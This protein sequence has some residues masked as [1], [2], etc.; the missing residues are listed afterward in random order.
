MDMPEFLSVDFHC[1]ATKVDREA[2]ALRG[3]T[4]AEAGVFRDGRGEFDRRGLEQIAT[5]INAD[6]Q[7]LKSRF[8]HP[9]FFSDGLGRF[10]GRVRGA[11][12][13]STLGK[14][15]KRVPAVKADLYFD[16]SAFNTPDGDLAGYTMSL[17]ES[18]S[19]AISSSLVI[20]P[21]QELQSD[22]SS[23][24]LWFPEELKASD[25]VE[26]GAAVG[27]LLSPD[28][29][30]AR[31]EELLAVA[32]TGK[33]RDDAW[34]VLDA[35]LVKAF[36]DKPVVQRPKLDSLSIRLQEMSLAAQRLQ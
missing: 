18:D 27:K 12:V 16:A 4:V 20:H 13:E 15:G 21:R 23:P 25:I 29:A 34:A 33:S 6:A 26:E 24:P 32:L 10:L 8:G 14:D 7:G 5:M 22:R 3:F 36:G 17:A 11:R 19:S 9:S 30:L 31:A 35:F 2:K 1:L 28:K